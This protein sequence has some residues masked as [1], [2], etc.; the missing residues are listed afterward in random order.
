MGTWLVIILRCQLLENFGERKMGFK[1][2]LMACPFYRGT[3]GKIDSLLHERHTEVSRGPRDDLERLH[4][5]HL[6]HDENSHWENVTNSFPFTEHLRG[7]PGEAPKS[8][9]A[10]HSALDRSRVQSG[11]VF[12]TK[13]K[14]DARGT[15]SSIRVWDC[16]WC[17]HRTPYCSSGE[18]SPPRSMISTRVDEH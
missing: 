7:S 11:T 18:I 2:S 5:L 15:P 13:T 16:C 9:C 12:R 10:T 8:I 14:M 1:L 6:F 3:M 4:S 17:T